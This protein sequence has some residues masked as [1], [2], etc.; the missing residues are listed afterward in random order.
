MGF[1]KND[2]QST[3]SRERMGIRPHANENTS[4]LK[5]LRQRATYFTLFRPTLRTV[6]HSFRCCQRERSRLFVLLVA[7][8]NR[9]YHESVW[10]YLNPRSNCDRKRW[11]T[12]INQ[13]IDSNRRFFCKMIVSVSWSAAKTMIQWKN[14]KITSIENRQISSE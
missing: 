7:C 6:C 14:E 9:S 5:R 8:G 3:H 11:K 12:V 2:L 10:F 1:S 13:N 4:T